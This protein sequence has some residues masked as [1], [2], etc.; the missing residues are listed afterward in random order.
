M[1]QSAFLMGGTANFKNEIAKIHFFIYNRNEVKT[2][3]N[4]ILKSI[5]ENKIIVIIRKVKKDL[6]M[7]LADA[8]Y[9]GGIRLMEVTYCG[10]GTFSEEETAENI[11]MLT[12]Y[13]K[14]KMFVG[15]GTVLTE[16]QVEMTKNAGG[17]F[18]ISPDTNPDVIKKTCS[19]G[20]VSMPGALTPTEIVA[21][22]RAGADFVK[23]FPAGDFGTSYIKAVRA[24]LSHIPM[25][26]VGGVDE[27]NLSEYFAAGISGIGVG[28]GIIKNKLLESGEFS[29]I[30]DLAK[31]YTERIQACQTI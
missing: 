18:I 28:S 9:E 10:D 12:E 23:I 30:T 24:P 25:L 11:R 13:M 26:A 14:G 3:K 31:V 4:E 2:L 7:P 16:K 6:L 21:A 20:M 5:K 22:H 15:A 19:L 27:N 17:S 1:A 29:K 8:L